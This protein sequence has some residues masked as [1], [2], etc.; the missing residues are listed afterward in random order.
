M[1]PCTIAIA[2]D[3]DV[4]RVT[5][6][7]AGTYRTVT[8]RRSAARKRERICWTDRCRPAVEIHGPSADLVLTL[9]NSADRDRLMASLG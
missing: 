5:I 9:E 1:R 3:G 4:C 6:D 2:P 8:T 7:E